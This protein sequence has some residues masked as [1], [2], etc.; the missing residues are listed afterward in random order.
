M[1]K[2][3]KLIYLLS[4]VVLVLLIIVAVKGGGG[5]DKIKVAT[6]LTSRRQIVETVSANG[7]I[8]PEVEVIITADVSGEIIELG[9]KEGDEVKEG[10]LLAVINPDIYMAARDRASASLNSSRANLANAK[11]RLAQ[12]RAQ[13]IRADADFKRNETLH[14]EGAIPDAEFDQAVASFEVAKAD[15]EAALQTVKAAEFN[16]ENAIAALK[17]SNDNL[18]KTNIFAPVDGTVYG[19]Q[20]EQGERVAGTSQFSEGTEIMRIANLDNM[21]ANVEVNENDIVRVS[22]GDSADIEVDAYLNRK[23]RGVVT[24]IANSAN[25]Q[26]INIEQVTTFNVK[27]RILRSSYADLL[28]AGHPGIS[29]FRPGMTATVEIKTATINDALAVPIQSVTVRLDTGLQDA[30]NKL[31]LSKK[32]GEDEKDEA[33]ECVFLYSDGK[34]HRSDVKT[35]I[36]DDKYIQIISGVEEGVEVIS[37]PYS[38]ISKK[39]ENNDDVEKVDKDQLYDTEKD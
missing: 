29:P 33:L 2:G 7:K 3:K 36:Q 17:E 35:G 18:K 13:R 5:R 26:G 27:I 6:E 9:V 16:V 37:A 32:P 23:F 22:L 8:Q 19:L 10:Q 25:V 11:A 28:D 4:G 14:K 38:V 39:L 12:S 31:R 21:E 34:A 24:E 20:K 1:F 30:G 15:E